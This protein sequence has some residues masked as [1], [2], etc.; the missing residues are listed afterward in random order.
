MNRTLIEKL[1]TKHEGIRA[2]VYKDTA[3]PPKLTIGIGFNL[4]APDALHICQMIGVDHRALLNGTAV[5]TVAE[6]NAIFDYQL[7]KVLSQAQIT[8]PTFSTFPD[9]VQA[10][11]CDMIF[12]MGWAA[13][14]SFVHT[15]ACIK[16]G[17]FKD[18]AANMLVSDWAKETPVR[19]K[20]DAEIMEA[21]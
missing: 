14:Q 18:A 9:E 15:I 6:I 10:V 1:I 4:E 21:A 16:S 5:L 12:Q 3:N 11:I 7:N 19:A 20:D 17:S 2:A 13:F 8:F